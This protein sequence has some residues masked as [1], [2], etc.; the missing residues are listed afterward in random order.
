MFAASVNIITLKHLFSPWM[1][2]FDI[3]QTLDTDNT[4]HDHIRHWIIHCFIFAMEMRWS[5]EK[6]N[7]NGVAVKRERKDDDQLGQ[8]REFGSQYNSG[9]GDS[10]QN[11]HDASANTLEKSVGRSVKSHWANIL[12]QW[13]TNLIGT[14]EYAPVS[15]HQIPISRVVG[16]PTRASRGA[17]DHPEDT[18]N[19]PF[20]QE[21]SISILGIARSWTRK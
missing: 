5:H 21:F 12:K 2:A 6:S 10:W 4:K 19:A 1:D 18:Y 8:S 14:F 20:F 17:A 13:Q 3:E 7:G 15:V 9:I 16:H 11:Y